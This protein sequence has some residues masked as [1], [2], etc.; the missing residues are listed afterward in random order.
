MFWFK[1]DLNLKSVLKL[2]SELKYILKWLKIGLKMN[3]SYIKKEFRIEN[4]CCI[5]RMIDW[6]DYL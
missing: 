4:S 1:S 2:V 5:V 6:T 3:F